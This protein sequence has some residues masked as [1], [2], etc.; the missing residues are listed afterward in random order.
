MY[1]GIIF[2]KLKQINGGQFYTNVTEERIA[3]AEKA[4]DVT[5][6]E[7]YK[8]FLRT[9]GEGCI[10]GMPYIYG[11]HEEDQK[12]IIEETK[13]L[14]REFFLAPNDVV[15]QKNMD[16]EMVI[17]LE[18]GEGRNEFCKVVAID[19][20][21]GTSMELAKSFDRYFNQ[22]MKQEFEKLVGN[23]SFIHG[24]SEET[25]F[26][27]GSE[28]GLHCLWNDKIKSIPN[29][30]GYKK[31]W[32]VI[33]DKDITLEE[34]VEKFNFYAREVVTYSDGVKKANSDSTYISI[35]NFGQG[36]FYILGNVATYFIIH[37]NYFEK[38]SEGLK[39]VFLFFTYRVSESHGFAVA[40]NGK[41]KRLYY[42]D[43]FD[44]SIY[45]LGDPLAEE[46]KLGLR[47]PDNMDEW[48]EN[49]KKLNLTKLKED[50]IIE[51]AMELT[52]REGEFNYEKAVLLRVGLLKE[53]DR[54]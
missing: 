51:I 7:D 43:D 31:E 16:S 26:F 32:I 13:K 24:E 40:E 3:Y 19:L 50:H 42:S 48:F 37:R 22:M 8:F 36:E 39:K 10:S 17:C 11:I 18:T 23:E 44:G 4:L 46:I 45:S 35:C 15:I 6:P 5:L 20:K 9:L 54:L 33:Q 25:P 53:K 14:R 12:G 27:L 30:V 52:G 49:R 41:I 38:F 21:T 1:D 47:L 29:G 34:I 28:T 2:R